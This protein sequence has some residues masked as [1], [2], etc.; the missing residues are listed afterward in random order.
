MIVKAAPLFA[1]ILC[2]WL[3]RLAIPIGDA[4][5]VAEGAMLPDI[6]SILVLATG[7]GGYWVGCNRRQIWQEWLTAAATCAFQFRGFAI[8]EEGAPENHGPGT[9]ETVSHRPM[10]VMFPRSP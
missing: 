3:G 6:V 8:S 10:G 5:S 7:F 9:P 4:D 1:T 2:R